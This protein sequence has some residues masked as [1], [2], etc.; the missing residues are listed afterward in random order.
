MNRSPE[1]S[2]A[3][4]EAGYGP[5]SKTGSS[6]IELPEPSIDRTFFASGA[7]SFEGANPPLRDD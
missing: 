2:K 6:A 4:T 7:R 1:G 5:Q 3:V